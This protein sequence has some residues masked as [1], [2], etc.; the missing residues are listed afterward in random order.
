VAERLDCDCGSNGSNLH[1]ARYKFLRQWIA[2]QGGGYEFGGERDQQRGDVNGKRETDG[3]DHHHAASN[4]AVTAGQTATFT[5]VASGTA[6]LSYQWQK[7]GTAISGATAASYTTPATSTSDSGSQFKVVVTNSAG[8][9]TSNA[10]T[11]TVNAVT[12]SVDVL[13][14]HNDIARTGQN[15]AETILTPSNVASATFGKIGFYSVDG[16]V[17]A[18]PLYASTVS[19]R[20]AARITC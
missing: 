12:S 2:V 18:E 17:D 10:A 13:T 11:L 4:K 5:V 16:L 7:G 1:H 15:L 6:P 9:V 20:V 8:S 3:T 19:F 14:Y